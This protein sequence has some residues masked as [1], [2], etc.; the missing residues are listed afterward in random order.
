MAEEKNKKEEEEVEEEEQEKGEETNEREEKEYYEGVGRRK[1]ST[2]VVRLYTKGA[3]KI[4]IN[5]EP[6][7]EYFPNLEMQETVTDALE[8]MNTEDKFKVSVMVEGGGLHSQA[9]AVRHGMARAL[10]D[11]NPSFKKRLKRVGYLTRDPRMK[12]R[13]KPGKRGARRSPQ[14]Q[15]R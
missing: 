5:D 9:E 13:K 11:L 3:S 1:T 4:M 15:K 8:E 10:V 12:E 6:Y 2:A 7:E 14:W